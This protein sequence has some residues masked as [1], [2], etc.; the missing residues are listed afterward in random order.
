MND[1]APRTILAGRRTIGYRRFGDG[2]PVA[3]LHASPRSSAALLPLGMRLADRFTVFAFDSPGF[4]WSDPLSV[5]RPDA[6][7]YAAALI[8]AFDMLGLRR[9]PLYGSHTGAAI[10]V[11][12]AVAYPDRVS[13]LALDGYAIFSPVEQAEFLAG[14][15]TPITPH[16]DGSHLA[17]LWGRVKDQFTVFPWHLRAQAARL[18]RPLP[19]LPMLQG[20]VQDFLAAGDNYRHA[21]AA[22]FRYDHLAGLR[23]V[24]VPTVA[25]ARADDL[26]FARLDLL[27]ELPDCVTVR[28]LGTDDDAW[29]AAVAQ[30]LAV[31]AS[32]PPPDIVPAAAAQGAM[33]VHRVPGGTIGLLR[34]LGPVARPLVLLPPMPGSACGQTGLARALSARR[35]VITSDLPGFAASALSGPLDPARIASSLRAALSSAGVQEFDVVAVGESGSIGATL[36]SL[37]PD[38]RL[39]LV[40]PVPDQVRNAMLDHMVDVSPRID[41]SHLLAAWHQLRDTTLWRPWFEPTPAH[42]IDAGPDPDTTA[43]QAVLTDWMRGGVSGRATLAAAMGQSLA[44]I[45]P[46]SAALVATPGHPWTDLLGST[47]ALPTQFAGPERRSRATAILHA[48]SSTT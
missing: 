41:G 4:G 16:W 44:G 15:L 22:A 11:A 8:E 23:Q 18:P 47:L 34:S 20:V 33:E 5:D 48:L 43:L 9:V 2:P 6:E 46:R 39:V 32:D 17:W 38:T 1:T 3:L 35:P 29:A 37:S 14:Y 12:A 40:D 26:L 7:D 31:G 10:A 13:S 24:R 36:A 25:M 28:R 42:A 30:A 27:T 45:L 19:A 21:Y